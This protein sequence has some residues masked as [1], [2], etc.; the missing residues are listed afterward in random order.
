MMMIVN[1]QN[2]GIDR[3]ESEWEGNNIINNY[4]T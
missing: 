3:A 2:T 4:S 1:M